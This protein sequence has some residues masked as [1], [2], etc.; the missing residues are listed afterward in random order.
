MN[1]E[2]RYGHRVKIVSGFWVGF[3]GIAIRHRNEKYLVQMDISGE[4]ERDYI[5]AEH[6]VSLEENKNK[7]ERPQ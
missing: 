4:V 2:I 5:D 6:V 3:D 7:Q 1:N